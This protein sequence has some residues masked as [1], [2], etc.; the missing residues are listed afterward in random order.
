MSR[1]VAWPTRADVSDKRTAST[2]YSVWYVV[3]ALV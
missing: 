1:N 3:Y 2:V